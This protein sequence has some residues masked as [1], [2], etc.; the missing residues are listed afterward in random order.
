M[1]DLAIQVCAEPGTDGARRNRLREYLQHAVLRAL[2]ERDVLAG[3]VFHGGTA[4]RILH[5]LPRYSEDLD[6][7][8]ASPDNDVDLGETLAFLLADLERS[9][10]EIVLA[11]KLA[12]NVHSCAVKFVGL[13]YECGLSPRPEA[14][15]S[16]K[17]EIDRRP[18]TGFGIEVSSVDL[19]FPYV[20]R[21][22]DRPTFIAGKL[23]AVLERPYPKGRDYYDLLFYLRR[24]DQTEPNLAYLTNALRQTEYE[25]ETITADNWRGIVAAKVEAVDWAQVVA[26]VDPFLLR[27]ADASALRKE[28]LLQLLG[29]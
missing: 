14:R 3:L 8:H 2:F 29:G 12:D 9:G 19:Y 17:L 15:L 5:D 26:D 13:L 20:V 22:H 21:H 10:Y 1:K 25:G 6:F 18:P 24:W 7:H 11:P 16:I 23:H 27:E 4:L 28:R